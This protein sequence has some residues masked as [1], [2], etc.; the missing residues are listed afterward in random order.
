[1]R[2]VK[3]VPVFLFLLLISIHELY[4]QA[5]IKGLV[6]DAGTGERLI[7]AHV[8]DTETYL[9]TITNEKGEFEFQIPE[10]QHQLIITFIG[11]KSEKRSFFAEAKRMIKM[12]DILLKPV[13][14][15]LKD[16]VVTEYKNPEKLI[17]LARKH[18]RRVGVDLHFE[19]DQ[20]YRWITSHDSIPVHWSEAVYTL[21]ENKN[22]NWWKLREG[23]MASNENA[24]QLP[25]VFYIDLI[26][27]LRNFNVF[28]K[29]LEVPAPLS[30]SWNTFYDFKIIR[31]SYLDSL[32]V[33]QIGITPKYGE[34]NLFRGSV[35]IETRNFNIVA[36]DI[37]IAKFRNPDVVQYDRSV[38]HKGRFEFENTSLWYHFRAAPISVNKEENQKYWLPISS[39]A[40]LLTDLDARLQFNKKQRIEQNLNKSKYHITSRLITQ[41]HS[42]SFRYRFKHFRIHKKE[43][44]KNSNFISELRKK[45]YHPDYWSNMYRFGVGKLDEK[46]VKY[47]KIDGKVKFSTK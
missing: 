14:Y 25:R 20:F 30:E 27:M 45:V 12:D 42:T 44:T 7:G 2:R 11:Y 34:M 28:E 43:A 16:L 13:I 9:G 17:R 10:G 19:V 41:C 38:I 31:R 5:I 8:Y 23:R 35:Y 15:Q 3:C 47:F 21:N 40:I 36:A 18:Y 1:M 22:D 24:P 33:Y 32:E 37:Y 6:K 46:T 29:L 4:A 26:D 39:D